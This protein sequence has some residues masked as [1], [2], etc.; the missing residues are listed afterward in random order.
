M[1]LGSN[2]TEGWSR[3]RGGRGRNGEKIG[4]INM[5]VGKMDGFMMSGGEYWEGRGE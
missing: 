5:G 4:G 1:G 2:G 3:I